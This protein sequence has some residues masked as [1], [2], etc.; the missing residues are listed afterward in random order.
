MTNVT[1]V[2]ILG[3]DYP[4]RGRADSQIVRD[5]M[6]AAGVNR[7]SLYR[8]GVWL[9]FDLVLLRDGGLETREAREWPKGEP[10]ILKSS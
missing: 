9:E 6:R 2:R 7:A 5:A 3:V 10:C 8:N 1:M 4:L